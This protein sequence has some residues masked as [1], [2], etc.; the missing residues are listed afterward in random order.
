LTLPRIAQCLAPVTLALRKA[1][2]ARGLLDQ[3]VDTTSPIAFQD[4]A[5][6]GIYEEADDFCIKFGR[7]LGRAAA[8][9]NKQ[10]F[11]QEGTDERNKGFREVA[12]VGLAK[13]EDLRS[14]LRVDGLAALQAWYEH[15]EDF[16]A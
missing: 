4:V 14:V 13:D 2:A 15:G 6:N 8:V 3:R 1:A 9:A 12:K 5:F 7:V 16:G 11:D 10:A